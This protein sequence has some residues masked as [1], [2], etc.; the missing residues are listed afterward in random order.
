MKATYKIGKRWKEGTMHIY[1]VPSPISRNNKKFYF[2][3]PVRQATAL[4]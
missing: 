3:E 4:N 2:P 1:G